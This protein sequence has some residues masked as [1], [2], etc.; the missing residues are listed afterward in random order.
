MSRIKPKSHV[1]SIP[2]PIPLG[3]DEDPVRTK[4]IRSEKRLS[5]EIGFEL[6]PGSGSTPRPSRKGDGSTDQFMIECKETI[7]TRISIG[8]NV[9]GKLCSEAAAVG[10][11]PV[12]ILSIYGMPEPLPKEWVVFPAN[13]FRS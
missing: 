9:I 5:L 10:K 8:P 12:L 4:S 3:P 7:G 1:P 13:L 11:D 6:T 2:R